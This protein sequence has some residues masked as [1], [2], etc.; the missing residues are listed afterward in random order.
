MLV[1]RPELLSAHEHAR[2]CCKVK[3]VNTYRHCKFCLTCPG[4]GKQR[5]ARSQDGSPRI[6]SPHKYWVISL[7]SNWPSRGFIGLLELLLPLVVTVSTQPT[8]PEA[9]EIR[10]GRI[11]KRAQEIRRA[12]PQHSEHADGN[13]N[14]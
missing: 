11:P 14:I 5:L 12:I 10:N 7:P 13:Q 6:Y 1:T 8:T 2:V 9:N 3:P 4:A